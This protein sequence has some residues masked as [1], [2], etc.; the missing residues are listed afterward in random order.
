V[1]IRLAGVLHRM[2]TTIAARTARKK[3][4]SKSI[5]SHVIART[6]I[7]KGIIPKQML[8]MRRS[9]QMEL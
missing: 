9:H 5:N 6:T 1:R 7:A 4:L 2:V 3:A 8:D